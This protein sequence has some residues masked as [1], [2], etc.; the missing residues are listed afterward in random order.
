M[1]NSIALEKPSVESVS[2]CAANL[3]KAPELNN[4]TL[5]QQN[6]RLSLSNSPLSTKTS[7]NSTQPISS[8]SHL[9]HLSS[10]T[11]ELTDPIPPAS[12]LLNSVDIAKFPVQSV[13]LTSANLVK[14]P[15]L[16]QSH[17]SSL[18][19]SSHDQKSVLNS[20]LKCFYTNATSGMNSSQP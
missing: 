4:S 17:P 18:S 5:N 2:L 8:Q 7:P 19:S 15:L 16:N 1:L 14:A 13:S 9:S 6:T 12:Y 20:A 11:L 3:V 10:S